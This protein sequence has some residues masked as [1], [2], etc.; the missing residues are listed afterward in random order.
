MNLAEPVSLPLP[1]QISIPAEETPAQPSTEKKWEPLLLKPTL[2]ERLSS[3][4]FSR[5]WR[6]VALAT[7]MVAFV[8][9]AAAAVVV[10][11]VTAPIYLPLALFAPLLLLSFLL[12]MASTLKSGIERFKQ[13]VKLAE[14]LLAKF[15]QIPAERDKLK[16]FIID[17]KLPLLL[18]AD[19]TIETAA[20]E[21]LTSFEPD[22]DKLRI[23]LAHYQQANAASQ[24]LLQRGNQSDLDAS[25]LQDKKEEEAPAKHLH[26]QIDHLGLSYSAAEQKAV[27]GFWL[28]LLLQGGKALP[29]TEKGQ[30]QFLTTQTA[31]LWAI[32][33]RLPDPQHN[34]FCK[35]GDTVVAPTPDKLLTM[36][37]QDLVSHIQ[38]AL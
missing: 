22:L 18:P 36:P 25:E 30:V 38:K 10:V 7:A 9:L 32:A 1:W 4:R 26:A 17:E 3:A 2:A 27:A 23:I 13:E 6:Q 5:T 31:K 12:P 11:G 29:R 8:V 16:Q 20:E 35:C 28:A 34:Y 21:I 24:I 33:P 37:M 14:A 19:K 15:R